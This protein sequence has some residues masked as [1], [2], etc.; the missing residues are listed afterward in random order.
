ML[1][2]RWLI[3]VALFASALLFTAHANL[4]GP[5]SGSAGPEKVATSPCDP[6]KSNGIEPLLPCAWD[7]ARRQ[8]RKRYSDYSERIG[9]LERPE[10]SFR[11]GEW[12]D[13]QLREYVVGDTDL[14]DDP[15]IQIGLTGDNEFDYETTVHEF[16]HY[17]VDRLKLGEAAH[18]W[19]DSSE[20][21][22]G[23]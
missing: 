14:N 8:M 15:P 17:V 1:K 11:K 19:I 13:R 23:R 12:Y 20:S 4:A 16:K 5:E 3:A 6:K 21:V 2:T 7:E 9:Q 22:P 10:I 18:R